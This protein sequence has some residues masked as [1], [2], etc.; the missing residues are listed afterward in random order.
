[1]HAMVVA[2]I[3]LV[4]RWRGKGIIEKSEKGLDKG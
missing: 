1:M 2:G 4:G 3:F